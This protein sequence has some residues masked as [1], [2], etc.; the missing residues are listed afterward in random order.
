[1]GFD[2]LILAGGPSARLDGSDKA[3]VEF[4]GATLLERAVGTVGEAD[5]VIVV[6]PRRDLPLA[7]P[8]IWIEEEP[9][10]GGP[11]AA[12]AAGLTRAAAELVAVLA[13]DHPLVTRDDVAR[14]VASTRADGAIAVDRNGRPQ[15][16]LAVYRKTALA[17]ALGR[18]PAT[19][20]ASLGEVTTALA[21]AEVDLGD[22]A[23]DC[24]TWDALEA[25]GSKARRQG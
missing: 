15:P 3:L 18:L 7:G 5:R 1:M 11:V 6:G 25:A 12:L 9:P 4:Q 2:A 17:A 24:D 8:V 20:G 14:L 10:R 23:D 19:Q 22:A 21:L 13:V 16:L